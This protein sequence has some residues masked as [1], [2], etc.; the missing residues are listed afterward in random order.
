MWCTSFQHYCVYNN[1]EKNCEN[2]GENFSHEA[3]KIHYDNKTSKGIYGKATEEET[4]ELL[5]EGIE[6]ASIPWVNKSEN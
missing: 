1:I 2:V 6:V 5:D 4:K 3:R